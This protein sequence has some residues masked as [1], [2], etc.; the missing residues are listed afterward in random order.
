[1]PHGHCFFWEPV[2]LW[3]FVLSNL[4]T[5]L[6][7]F[8]IPITLT[9][10]VIKRKDM[11]FIGIFVLFSLFIATCG[12]THFMNIWTI[13]RPD[14]WL[15][16]FLDVLVAVVSLITAVALYRAVPVALTIPAP[17]SLEESVNRL[18][19]TISEL[20][21]TQDKLIES[22]KLSALGGLVAGV[23]HELNTPIGNALTAASSIL[24]ANQEFRNISPQMLRRSD[25]NYLLEVHQEGL[26]LTL[27]NLQRAVS[28]IGSFKELSVNDTTGEYKP[29]LI[30]DVVRDVLLIFENRLTSKGI[31]VT[32]QLDARLSMRSYP[33]A[34]MQLLIN[35]FERSLL[36]DFQGVADPAIHLDWKRVNDRVTLLFWDNGA[37][38]GRKQAERVFE[39]FHVIGQ[40]NQGLG[41]HICYH[42]VNGPLQGT[43]ELQATEEGR[44]AAFFITL[45][46][47]LQES[48]Q[49][50]QVNPAN[51][52]VVGF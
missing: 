15:Q 34:L 50:N 16:A 26:E 10:F 11:G 32:C 1:M 51:S 6:A 39:P 52:Q 37:P 8:S 45:P 42:L 27:N 19:A 9:F 25:L 40:G 33:S 13:W 29:F 43:I 23:A 24:S 20:R 14:Y 5:A 28:L 35:L 31:T 12:L 47:A 18:Q 44:G 48:T 38:I 7:Y 4:F 22:E 17:K 46:A 21:F 49:A 36:V 41:L 30:N 3:T 2:L